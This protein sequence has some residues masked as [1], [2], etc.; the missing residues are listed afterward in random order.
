MKRTNTILAVALGA[1]VALAAVTWGTRG[2]PSGDAARPFFDFEPA[3]VTAVTLTNK[4]SE[5]S[6]ARPLTLTKKGD[7]WVVS[8]ADDYPA[9]A[10]KVDEVVNKRQ[11]EETKEEVT[12]SAT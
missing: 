9:K 5:D 4:G 2:G 10:E 3:A 8:T 12:A 1:Q 7:G 6:P 11:A